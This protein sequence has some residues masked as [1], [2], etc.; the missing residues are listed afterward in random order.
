[1]Q[2][3][4]QNQSCRCKKLKKTSAAAASNSAIQSCNCQK[5]NKLALQLPVT[6]LNNPELQQLVNQ[7]SIAEAA[8]NSTIQIF[9][10][11]KLN[12]PELHQSIA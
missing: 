12:K 3:T 5:L 2:V 11:Q 1:M 4:Q 7:R 10:C 8:S 6:K 9:S